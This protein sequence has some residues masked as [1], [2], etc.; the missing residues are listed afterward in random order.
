MVDI[1]TAIQNYTNT[2]NENYQKYCD[3]QGRAINTSSPSFEYELKTKYAIVYRVSG[4]A[5]SAHAFV[6]LS[7]ADVF[8]R[9]TILKPK[10]F[11]APTKNFS[12]GNVFGDFKKASNWSGL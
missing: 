8:P 1:D 3:R 11:K 10:N 9:G 6:V 7:D 12:R 2:C 5:R 4:T